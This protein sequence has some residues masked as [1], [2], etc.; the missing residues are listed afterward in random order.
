MPAARTEQDSTFP[1]KVKVAIAVQEG[2][3]EHVLRMVNAA[4]LQV[5]L[6]GCGDWGT[7]ILRDLQ[8]LGCGVTVADVN[9]AARERALEQGAVRVCQTVAELPEVSGAVVAV[10]TKY[11]AL[12]INQLL[13]RWP[14]L[15]IYC[16]KPLCTDLAEARALA[17]RAPDNVFVMEK[18]RYHHGVQALAAIARSSELG[19][20][21]SMTTR[22]LSWGNRHADDVDQVWVLMPH[23]LSI[24]REV[25]GHIPT[26][27]A[28]R[29]EVVGGWPVHMAALL[30]Q[31]PWASI[32]ISSRYPT[33]TRELRLHCEQGFATLS[34][35]YDDFVTIVKQPDAQSTAA[36][37]V[38]RRPIAT[39]WPLETQL[40]VFVE[41]IRGGPPP[42]SS[43]AEGVQAIEAI[44]ELRRLAGADAD[45]SLAAAA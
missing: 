10:D 26:P 34:G 38:E 22:R 3:G 15:P 19:P 41:H 18:W 44:A 27:L 43:A 28:A 45:R 21:I 2:T 16:E 9:P 35:S 25:L 7:N 33:P 11:H 8:K 37:V 1:A 17:E 4:P 13:D 14:T 6:V 23:D 29:T 5:A 40:R 36:P 42:K 32:E 12:I 24:V 31:R 39:G 20:V 30:G